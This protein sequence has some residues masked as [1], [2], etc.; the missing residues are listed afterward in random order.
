MD[1]LDNLFILKD[2]PYSFEDTQGVGQPCVWD[3]GTYISQKE[4]VHYLVS[5]LITVRRT[6][7]DG[8]SKSLFIVQK[9]H[10]FSRYSLCSADS[11]PH[12][13]IDAS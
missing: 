10:F 3:R 13:G 5:G 1:D 4:G 2:N 7:E 12:T 9:K 6:L 8:Q 11:W